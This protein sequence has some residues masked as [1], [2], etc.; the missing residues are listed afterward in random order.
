MKIKADIADNH[1]GE[2]Y[3]KL[4]IIGN[5]GINLV[6]GKPRH[7]ALCL[8]ECGN[9]KPIR[10]GHVLQG[11]I[12]S[13]GCARVGRKRLSNSYERRDDYIVVYT[14]QGKEFYIDKEDL[15]FI[16]ETYYYIDDKGYAR[17]SNH[18]ALHDIIMQPTNGFVVDHINHKRN[19]NRRSNLRVCTTAENCRNRLKSGGVYQTKSG[20]W[21]S[22]IS[23]NC[24]TIY[25]GT[26]ANKTDAVVARRAAEQI[27]YGEYASKEAV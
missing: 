1:I 3:N 7:M 18:K 21:L 27:Y 11:H 2:K 22:I 16:K 5:G 9:T 23:V 10:L 19:D 13:C 4:T 15:D 20:K 24:K 6:G 8:C 17:N 26:F 25:L 14:N 12:K